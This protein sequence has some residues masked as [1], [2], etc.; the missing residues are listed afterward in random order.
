[1][2]FVENLFYNECNANTIASIGNEKD[3]KFFVEIHKTWHKFKDVKPFVE[4]LKNCHK[5]KD[6]KLFVEIWKAR[7]MIVKIYLLIFGKFMV[8][9]ILKM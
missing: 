6:V 2:E 8:S 1:M 4:I 5:F 7:H 9:N 3:I